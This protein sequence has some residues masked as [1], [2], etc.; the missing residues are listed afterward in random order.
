MLALPGQVEHRR[1][2][3]ANTCKQQQPWEQKPTH[4]LHERLLQLGFLEGL[5][6]QGSPNSPT[7][8]DA[9]LRR[10]EVMLVSRWNKYR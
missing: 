1:L 9:W 4:F 10:M 8:H 2:G 7:Q 5:A 3:L 6:K